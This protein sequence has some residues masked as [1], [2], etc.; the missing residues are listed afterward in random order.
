MLHWLR[1]GS[2]AGGWTPR[3]QCGLVRR[4]CYPRSAGVRRGVDRGDDPR[5]LRRLRREVRIDSGQYELWHA[6]WSAL[7]SVNLY[8]LDAGLGRHRALLEH[9]IPMTF[10][11]N[12]DVTRVASQI[13]DRRHLTHAVALLGFL[14]GVPSVS[15]ATS[16][17]C[18]AVKE[19]R[20]G[21]DD[22]VRPEL[23]A[24]RGQ[25]ANYHPE[26]ETAYRQILGLRRRNPWLVDAV[27]ATAEVAN[28]HLVV[29]AR[30]A[31]TRSAPQPGAQ[32]GRP[33]VHAPAWGRSSSRRPRWMVRPS[34]RTAGPCSR[35]TDARD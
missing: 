4:R 18:E 22:A 13:R 26:V 20:P 15:T 31:A 3:T 28:E 9:L 33:S 19:Q 34:R 12:H 5:R 32:P 24:E 1:R 10:L 7:D 16:S 17:A 14:P 27:I 35:P 6:I 29:H 21:G 23:P 11:S 30:L 25:F 2:T 8:A